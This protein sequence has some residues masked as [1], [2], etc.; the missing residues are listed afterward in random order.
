MSSTNWPAGLPFASNPL[1]DSPT[2]TRDAAY[3]WTNGLKPISDG[4][5]G[6]VGSGWVAPTLTGSWVL[7]PASGFYPP[8]YKAHGIQVRLRG[9]VKNGGTGTANPIFTMPA[10][11]APAAQLNFTVASNSGGQADLI[12][13]AAG[14]LY[15]SSYQTGGSNAWIVLDSIIY[16]AD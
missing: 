16:T 2:I 10:A 15:V 4:L 6:L 7:D 13:D 14:R 11:L 1:A 8:G 9:R 3:F 5:A 12:M